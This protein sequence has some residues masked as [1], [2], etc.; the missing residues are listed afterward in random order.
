MINTGFEITV[1]HNNGRDS[2]IIH[3]AE[4][5]N[6]Y[7]VTEL[8]PNGSYDFSVVAFSRGANVI[9]RSQPSN[10]AHFSG[11]NCMELNC[12][13]VMYIMMKC[14][15]FYQEVSDY[16]YKRTIHVTSKMSV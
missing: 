7:D 6:S 4:D 1:F 8:K 5:L 9:G 10:R 2:K 3:I 14:R 11:N 13:V 15:F 12:L 16:Q